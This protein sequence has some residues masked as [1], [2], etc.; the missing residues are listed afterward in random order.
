MI[1]AE[2]EIRLFQDTVVPI[3]EK[4]GMGYT[5]TDDVENKRFY[6]IPSGTAAY[7]GVTVFE[8]DVAEF[9][10]NM[11][12]DE[13]P[14]FVAS[15]SLITSKGIHIHIKKLFQKKQH[16]FIAWNQVP[17]LEWKINSL[18]QI[19]LILEGNKVIEF[20]PNLERL[21]L[22]Q[23]DVWNK[24]TKKVTPLYQPDLDNLTKVFAELKQ[25]FS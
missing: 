22:S 9:R 2:N 20:Q 6:C 8:A 21:G 3:F 14:I 7:F 15:K 10:A 4:H 18:Q 16:I 12:A 1:Q 19:E 5:V 25:V 13:L 11:Q 23:D 17:D 24:G